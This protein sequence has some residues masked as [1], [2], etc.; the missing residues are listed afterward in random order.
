MDWNKVSFS[1]FTPPKKV[2]LPDSQNIVTKEQ[3]LATLIKYR[4]PLK[5]KYIWPWYMEQQAPAPLLVYS[6]DH[7]DGF[8]YVDA[9]TGE[10]IK[11]PIDQEDE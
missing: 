7:S 4:T 11:E 1:L 6:W 5:L 2:E 10:Y 8:G 9:I 3:A